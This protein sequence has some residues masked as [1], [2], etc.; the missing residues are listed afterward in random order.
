MR[1]KT[2]LQIRVVELSKTLPPIPAEAETWAFNTL[3]DYF[4]YKTNH[5]AV[6]FECG[7]SWDDHTPKATLL[8]SIGGF[9]C[10]ECGKALKT[11]PNMKQSV[12]DNDY[13]FIATTC[14][15][16]QVL[17]YF[18]TYRECKLNEKSFYHTIEV[19]QHWINPDGKT[20]VM[21]MLRNCMSYNLYWQWG[22]ELEIR[23]KSDVYF[24]PAT[25]YPKMQIQKNIK[26]NG[27]KGNF[28]GFNPSR[29]FSLLLSNPKVETL[30]KAGYHALF[31]GYSF[32]DRIEE[33]WPL[34]KIC[35]RNKYVIKDSSI[36]FDH[37]GL[38]KYFHYDVHNPKYICSPTLHADHQQLIARKQ[39]IEDRNRDAQRKKIEAENL[40]FRMMKKKF[41]DLVFTDGELTIVVLK[42]VRD[43]QTEGR[44]LKHCVYSSNYHKKDT[45]LLMSAR[46][47]KERLETIELSLKEAKVLQCRGL[48]NKNSP[49]HDDILKLVN[50]NIPTIKKLIKQSA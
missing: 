32:E 3:F 39:R 26:R 34:I 15:E 29:L 2:K 37:I 42:N 35:L 47:G 17:R 1:P 44:I 4:I 14:E 5:K 12:K 20:E 46:K 33:H 49:Y 8:A 22:S 36:W 24:L 19:F 11:L 23:N 13:F 16:F 10:P 31:N 25:K 43:V 9:V 6:C 30:F 38:L 40:A 28:H 41:F 48:E 45:S 27:F 50:S 21:G 18:Y 7:H